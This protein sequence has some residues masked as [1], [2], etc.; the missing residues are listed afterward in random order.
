MI[1]LLK[2]VLLLPIGL[3]SN[4]AFG[5]AA[6]PMGMWRIHASYFSI[7]DIK[8]QQNHVFAVSPTGLMIVDRSESSITTLT[9]MNGL[10]GSAISDVAAH[11]STNQIIIVY[12]DGTFDVVRSMGSIE[13]FDPAST[14]VITGSKKINDVNLNGSFAYFSTDY[15]VLVFDLNV[16][17]IKETWRD[18]GDDGQ[19]LPV[20]QSTFSGDSIFLATDEGIIAGDLEDNLLDYNNWKRME[21]NGGTPGINSIAAFNGDLLISI[22]NDG[23]YKYTD[24]QWQKQPFLDEAEVRSMTASSDHLVVSLKDEVALIDDSGNVTIVTHE[25]LED[26]M[27]AVEDT[28]GILWIGDNSSGLLSW[29]N[30]TVQ[31]FVAN[32]PATSVGLRLHYHDKKMYMVNGGPTEVFAPA[33]NPGRVSIFENGLWSVID[34]SIDDITDVVI[35]TDGRLYFSSFGYGIKEISG[36]TEKIYDESNSSLLNVNAPQR[37]VNVS[38][39]LF[40]DGNLWAANYG[41]SAPLHKLSPDG[42]WAAFGFPEAAGKYILD[43]EK[44]W[45]GRIWSRLDPSQGGGLSVLNPATGE[46]RYLTDADN[47]GE[48]PSRSVYAIEEDR[49]GYVWVGTDRGAAYFYDA[50]S[51]VVRPIIGN[52][53]LLLD[54]RVT[55]IESDGGNRKWMGTQRGAWLISPTGEESVLHFTTQNSPLPSDNILDIEIDQKT[56]EVFFL[57]DKGLVSY[58]S[59]ATES[60]PRFSSVRIFPN[61]IR[62]NFTGTV[63]ITGLATDALVKITDITGRMIWQ[64]Q[65]N[66]GSIS[67]NGRTAEGNRVSNGIYLVFSA[68]PTGTES[69]VGKVAVID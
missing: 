56:G 62:A 7:L 15:G 46:T 53:Y 47:N 18:I 1:R 3:F 28:Q 52:I 9:R 61:P 69:M 68:T 34:Q 60:G 17:E 44:D 58:R 29:Q 11:A 31:A 39:L 64:S 19:T 67:W 30:N 63:G 27:I 42:N 24:F 2:L 8:V 33:H 13:K 41:A 14:T 48:L 54:D 51:D 57:T 55:A 45:A 5:Q 66:G 37:Y 65:A 25:K 36:D 6:I 50:G 40:H 49:D 26:V 43:L 38:T 32:G 12:E 10:S 20:Y 23:I 21:V 35:S 4:T 59:D 16:S 22:A